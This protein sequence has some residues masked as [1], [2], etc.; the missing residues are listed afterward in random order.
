[1][2]LYPGKA[3][4]NLI[5]LAFTRCLLSMCIVQKICDFN[6]F[7]LCTQGKPL[8]GCHIWTIYFKHESVMSR[9]NKWSHIW[10]SH[11]IY[12]SVISCIWMS[13]V[14]YKWVMS[15]MNESRHIGTN[16]FTYEWVMPHTNESYHVIRRMNELCHHMN[17]SCH[18]WISHAIY[19]WVMSQMNESCHIC[20]SHV[21]YDW[22]ISNAKEACVNCQLETWRM[23]F[24][25][26]KEVSL[27]KSVGTWV[28]ASRTANARLKIDHCSQTRVVL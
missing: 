6:L 8:L 12:D 4:Q 22:D 1:M 28:G 16:H 23:T 17:D 10:M 19:E 14:T 15:R 21:A 3:K 5:V 18:V 9:M 11:I 27:Y 2:T 26:E 7:L 20:M 13:P 24:F 25:L